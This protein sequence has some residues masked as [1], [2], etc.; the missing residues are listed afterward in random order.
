MFKIQITQINFVKK[1]S[2]IVEIKWETM[3]GLIISHNYYNKGI[4]YN[5]VFETKMNR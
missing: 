2:L 1:K 5:D 4:K 3:W